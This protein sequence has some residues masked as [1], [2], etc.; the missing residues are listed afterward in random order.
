MK[1][2]TPRAT[3]FATLLILSS[4]LIG[5]TAC[6]QQRV[7]SGSGAAPTGA[8]LEPIA[9]RASGA[10]EGLTDKELVSKASLIVLG[11]VERIHPSRWNTSDGLRPPNVTIQTISPTTIIFTDVDIKV[12]RYL[13]GSTSES[14]VRVRTL[15]GQV[16]QDSM[17]Y[18]EEPEFQVS[19][20][21]IVFLTSEDVM[22]GQI[23]PTH[24]RVVGAIQGKFDIEGSRATSKIKQLPIDDLIKLIQTAQ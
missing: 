17:I 18:S 13:K 20:S 14:V 11:T 19:R 5:L 4:L 24:Y 9:M 10:L 15:G 7:Q 3:L 21:V 1:Y 12:N 6:G 2:K 8:T 23:G 16:G 22:A